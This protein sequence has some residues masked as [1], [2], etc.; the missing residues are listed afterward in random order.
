MSTAEVYQTAQIR[1]LE[2][3]AKERF[4][5]SGE[6]M[7]QRAGEAALQYFLKR[8]HWAKRVTVVC[9]PGNNGGDGYVFAEK[10]HQRGLSVT[11]LQ[12][13]DAN[14]LKNEAK[15]AYAACQTAGVLIRPFQQN[16]NLQ[17]N[18]VIVDAIYGIGLQ[19]GIRN[20][21]RFVIEAINKSLIP[22]LAIDVPSGVDA[23]TGAVLGDAVFATCTIT[24][25]GEK[26]GLLTGAGVTYAGDIHCDDLQLP[27]ELFA[28]IT[29]AIER[30]AIEAFEVYLK[31]RPRD[32]YK[33]DAGHVLIVGG[34]EGYS[35]APLM[36][37][38]AALRVGAGLVTVATHPKH[39]SFLNIMHPEIMCQ[40]VL[41][42]L[43]L[44]K[45]LKKATIVVIG[46]GMGKTSWSK[47]LL[48]TVLKTALPLVVD[49]DGLNLI[50]DKPRKRDNWILTPHPGEA[51][52]LLKMTT[53]EVQQDR[54]AALQKMQQIYSGVAILKGAGTLVAASS[55]P[56]AVCNAGNPGM[57]TGGMGDVLS[58]V[59]GGL[60]A[61]GLPLADA[62]KLGVFIHARAGDLAAANGGE[63]GL[64]ATDLMPYLRQLMN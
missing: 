47:M 53:K 59:L 7:M 5:I 56:S 29:G 8:W 63:R 2:S 35:G 61:Q 17:Q 51:S 49:A 15:N 33:G 19:A 38:L 54:Y 41:T 39:A 14:K 27:H 44:K 12:V 40:G 22:V 3:L 57:G 4:G 26:L 24:F 10:A 21:D 30:I 6:V 31:P 42:S 34:D 20:E 11:V 58:G 36:A 28:S 60:V 16:E 23:N 9:G 55:E 32:F 1:Q 64:M 43:T 62:A 13:G 46:P 37:A 48:K 45:L 18:D 50:A 52:R 25:I